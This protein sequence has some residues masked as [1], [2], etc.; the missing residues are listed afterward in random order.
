M[1][2]TQSSGA[3]ARGLGTSDSAAVARRLFGTLEWD[4]KDGYHSTQAFAYVSDDPMASWGAWA[5]YAFHLV[6]HGWSVGLRGSLQER[7]PWSAGEQARTSW[8]AS[9]GLTR[10]VP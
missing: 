2:R 9:L 1:L 5:G 6:N 7:D 4:S 8:G 3:N 10:Q